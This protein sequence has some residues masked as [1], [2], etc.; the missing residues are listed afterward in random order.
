MWKKAPQPYGDMG[1]YCYTVM[2]VYTNI[3][4][5]KYLYLLMFFFEM[6]LR[7]VKYFC[8]SYYIL[9]KGVLFAAL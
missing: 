9:I 3:S 6:I 7:S 1:F 8:W 5:G 2:E 4:Q